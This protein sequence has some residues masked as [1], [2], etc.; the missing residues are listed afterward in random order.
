MFGMKRLGEGSVCS[1]QDEVAGQFRYVI[2]KYLALME[3]RRA[4]SSS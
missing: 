3:R 4:L 1:K 2:E